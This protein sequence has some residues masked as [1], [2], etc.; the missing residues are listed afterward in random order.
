VPAVADP[1]ATLIRL[2]GWRVTEAERGVADC[3]AEIRRLDEEARSLAD[4][5]AAEKTGLARMTDRDA[6]GYGGFARRIALRQAAVV[7]ARQAGEEG[8]AAARLELAEAYRARR[9]LEAVKAEAD[10]RR[11]KT[12]ARREQAGLDEIAQRSRPR[13]L[14]PGT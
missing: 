2:A 8:L 14:V 12:L 13:S 3:L 1:L 4:G 9:K 6:F 7:A 10:G 5:L 11:A